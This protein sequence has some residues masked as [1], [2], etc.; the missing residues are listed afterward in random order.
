MLA[1]HDAHATSMSARRGWRLGLAGPA[2]F[3]TYSVLTRM[4]AGSRLPPDEA[5]ALL[6]H[7]FPATRFLDA[8]ALADLSGRLARLGISGGAVYDALV[9]ETARV[10]GLPLLTLDRRALQTYTKV[11]VDVRLI[12]S[13]G[14]SAR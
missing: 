9:A 12:R 14:A 6:A 3:E 4:P 13:E 11:G 8:T 5:H 10:H 7:D 2:G 1:S